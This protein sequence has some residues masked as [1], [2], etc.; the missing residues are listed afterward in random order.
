M[1]K[2]KVKFPYPLQWFGDLTTMAWWSDLWLNEGLASYLEFLGADAAHPALAFFEH[3]YID[4]VPYA[5]YF[6]SK[7]ASHPMSPPAAGVNSTDRIE[8]LFDPVE[9]EKG[10]TLLRMLRAWINRGNA[11]AP[12]VDGWESSAAAT[13]ALTPATDPFLLGLSQYLQQYQY[14][15]TTAPQF[16]TALSAA[17]GVEL[18]PLMEAWTYAQGY[19]MITVSVDAKR[20]VWVQ[21]APF[22]LSGPAPCDSTAAWWVPISFVSS[23]ATGTPKW[24]E[25]NACQS[26]RPLLPT[27]PKGGWVKVNARQYGYYRVNYVPELWDALAL[28][29]VQRDDNGFPVMKGVDVAGLL[30]D[31]Y[32]LAEAGV[33]DILPFLQHVKALPHRP[34][35]EYSPW[36]AALPYLYAI[37]RMAPCSD[38]WR[39]FVRESLIR[40]FTANATVGAAGPSGTPVP[41]V[42]SFTQP[43]VDPSVEVPIGVRLLRPEILKAAGYF[44]ET[45][46][47]SEATQLLTTLASAS[48]QIGGEAPAVGPD[49]LSVIYQTAAHSSPEPEQAFRELQELYLGA[50]VADQR[51]RVLRAMSYSPLAAPKALEFAL[52]PAVK[53]QDV[54]TLVV[55]TAAHA[56]PEAARLTWDWFKT[57]WDRLHAKLGGDAEA[58][59]RMGQ[60]L[61][62][63]ASASMDA[64]MLAEVD[65]VYTAHQDKQSEPGYAQRAKEVIQANAKWVHAHGESTCAWVAEQ[66]AGAAGRRR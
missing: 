43:A 9:Y 51:D 47:V 18:G 46:L 4:D 3:F 27:L 49:V 6:D 66:Q 11:S 30:E 8:G 21:Q 7:A 15:A 24:M 65:E 10:A 19:P 28:A 13:G 63:V 39:T 33:I 23:E 1:F 52:T 35:T 16:W 60:I 36:A 32:T 50:R 31:S 22:A 26:L 41:V 56:G 45:D 62:G 42:F 14:N 59:R 17:V 57:N 38:A 25:L 61:E 34:V 20:S 37:D 29:A 44:G 2:K 48:Q 40:P 12:A 64:A 53:A 58:S 5:L 55:A 54:R